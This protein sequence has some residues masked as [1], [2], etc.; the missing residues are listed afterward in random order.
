MLFCFRQRKIHLRTT[1][2]CSHSFELALPAIWLYFPRPLRGAV[3]FAG[4][5]PIFYGGDENIRFELL[6]DEPFALI[7]SLKT[8]VFPLFI[9]AYAKD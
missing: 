2:Y 4:A 8:Y 5:F 7:A 6:S 3:M 1:F 9:S